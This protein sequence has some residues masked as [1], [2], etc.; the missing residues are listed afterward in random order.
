MSEKNL[1]EQFNLTLKK[2]K[3][4]FTK[5][6][7]VEHVDRQLL[8][9]F[10][11]EGLGISYRKDPRHKAL[12]TPYSNEFIQ[13]NNYLTLMTEDDLFQVNHVLPNHGW[14]RTKAKDHLSLN[15]FYRPTRHAFCKDNY[16]DIDMTSA[17]P[18]IF[19]MFAKAH[20][21]P[22]K[23]LERYVKEPTVMRNELLQ[24]HYGFD[25]SKP[26][27]TVDEKADYKWV[28]KTLPLILCYGGGY[29]T[30]KKDNNVP[31][32]KN[33]FYQPF[34]DLQ[35]E[36]QVLMN[37]VFDANPNILTDLRKYKDL[38]GRND[39][40]D[41]RT[42]FA[43]WAQTIERIILECVCDYL[44]N[45]FPLNE[46]IPCQDGFMILKKY[47]YDELVSDINAHVLDTLGWSIT[48]EVKPFDQAREDIPRHPRLNGRLKTVNDD[49]TDYFN[50]PE[51]SY[52][53]LYQEKLDIDYSDFEKADVFLVQSG[54][55]TGKSTLIAKLCE[56]YKRN[57]PEV[58]ILCLSSL[59]SILSQ[60]SVTFKEFG[61]PLTDYR[62][63][64]KVYPLLNDDCT[65]CINSLLRIADC[66][67]TDSILYIDEPVNLLMGS[68]GNQTIDNCTDVFSQ[69]LRIVRECRKVVFTDAHVIKAMQDLIDI[70][71][72]KPKDV[73][74]Y[75]NTYQRFKDVEAFEVADTSIL[76][77]KMIE[78][79][80]SC[81]PF[82]FCTDGRKH[83][84]NYYKMC[85]DNAPDS[86]KDKFVLITKNTRVD[87]KA[88]DYNSSYVFM[89]PTVVCGL[90]IVNKSSSDTFMYITGKSIN[91]ISL[92]QQCTRNRTMRNLYYF[93]CNK[94]KNV[95]KYSC[96]EDCVDYYKYKC[97]QVK[98]L[99]DMCRYMD[100]RGEIVY[101]NNFYFNLYT[102]KEYSES[103]MFQDIRGRF[104]EELINA[105]FK[106]N[107]IEV[108]ATNDTPVK[109]S[110]FGDYYREEVYE[111][112][113]ENL[114]SK[115]V[116]LS[117]KDAYID[118]CRTLKIK[119][120]EKLAE[121]I[122]LVTDDKLYSAYFTFEKYM[123]DYETVEKEAGSVV[124]TKHAIDASKSNI[125]KVYLVKRFEKELKI[126]PLDLDNFTCVVLEQGE[127]ME[128]LVDE[129]KRRFRIGKGKTEILDPR[130]VEGCKV[131]YAKILRGLFGDKIP[132]IYSE[133][134]G[135]RGKRYRE[136]YIDTDLLKHYTDV[137]H[138]RRYNDQ[139]SIL[140]KDIVLYVRS[141]VGRPDLLHKP[142]AKVD[143]NAN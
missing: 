88:V 78:R 13:M 117:H 19:L 35:K 55:G 79:V 7:T 10:I 102:H 107:H 101:V 118:R 103:L 83:A 14:G 34:V 76:R 62:D 71:G 82:I 1:E 26:G 94:N 28:A 63:V 129:I 136:Y 114:E 106:I 16:V 31:L 72:T 109:M 80:K 84:E 140:S 95:T 51:L 122:D 139:P 127:K 27:L 125:M 54:T 37:K 126:K 29:K 44:S 97:D 3:S 128:Y 53:E 111:E 58:N 104:T 18:T 33:G 65:M 133:Q 93:I 108:S 49:E 9:G 74:Y 130:T 57:H 138:S 40:A 142:R 48:F 135:P 113:F 112:L 90:S 124:H 68:A 121:Y 81:T 143:F 134:M 21:L 39:H 36:V 69:L 20:N 120:K 23:V 131:I 5:V 85:L 116:D 59:R 98:S 61:M 73:Y 42:V 17:H 15:I 89:S 46:L 105:G 11:N 56:E 91:T 52:Y 66:D 119:T 22:C 87:L 12:K 100:T 77:D 75:Y 45:W 50:L 41:K 30:W 110:T 67:V 123:C 38:R 86:E 25:L 6:K 47:Y 92:Y 24:Y 32:N 60:L 96:Y 70:R 8:Y 64:E 2:T 99:R 137:V 115:Y 132:L 4:I 141:L 43:M